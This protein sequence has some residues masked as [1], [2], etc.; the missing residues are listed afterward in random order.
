MA[1]ERYAGIQALRFFLFLAIFL[2]HCGFK[3]AAM[4]WFGVEAFLVLSTFLVFDKWFNKKKESPQIG[5][6]IV[7]RWARL[8]PLYYALLLVGLIAVVTTKRAFPND[9]LPALGYMQNVF[10][11]ITGYHSDSISL[12]AHTWYL[13]ID[14]ALFIVA[15][16]IVRVVRVLQSTSGENNM[17]INRGGVLCSITVICTVITVFFRLILCSR[18]GENVFILSLCPL[19]YLDS[20][21]LGLLLA[22]LVSKKSQVVVRKISIYAVVVGLVGIVLTLWYTSNLYDCGFFQGYLKYSSPINYL[23]NPVTV[24]I[25]SWISLFSMG[26]IGLAIT[27]KNTL[28]GSLEKCLVK[29]GDVSYALYII[30]WPLIW[31]SKRVVS[32]TLHYSAIAFWG[33]VAVTFV[34][35]RFVEPHISR[36]VNRII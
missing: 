4:G 13:A 31:A 25:F 19:C 15:I 16:L 28:T 22:Q 23:K 11:R 2:F 21:A 26:A 14:F 35:T 8:S 29:L 5:K 1:K 32:Q 3:F 20:L 34:W 30:H 17:D 12:T 27:C 10:W 24:Q 7:H 36:R 18:I 6:Q 9:F 33:T